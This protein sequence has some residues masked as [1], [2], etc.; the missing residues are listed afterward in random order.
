MTTMVETPA[1]T[2]IA[3]TV[4]EV[5]HRAADLLEEFGWCQNDLGSKE[6]GEFCAL[7]ALDEAGLELGLPLFVVW[8]GEWACSDLV[9]W[10]NKPGRTKAEVVAKLREAAESA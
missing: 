7:G 3:P 4:R 9:N 10:N 6:Q 8:P 2:R 5:L 1:E